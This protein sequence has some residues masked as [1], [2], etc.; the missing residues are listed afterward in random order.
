MTSTDHSPPPCGLSVASQDDTRCPRALHRTCWC[1]TP[2]LSHW[3]TWWRRCWPVV[4]WD[5]RCASD[6]TMHTLSTLAGKQSGGRKSQRTGLLR[7]REG[8][9]LR[10]PLS[11]RLGQSRRTLHKCINPSYE[12]HS[13]LSRTRQYVTHEGLRQRIFWG[14]LLCPPMVAAPTRQS[15]SSVPYQ[16]RACQAQA[17]DGS[18]RRLRH[19]VREKTR[20][21]VAKTPEFTTAS[22]STRNSN[23]VPRSQPP[24]THRPSKI[25]KI[26]QNQSLSDQSA[27][28][29]G[30]QVPQQPL[31]HSKTQTQNG[32]FGGNF[33]T[34]THGS[35][36]AA[37]D[38]VK[39]GHSSRWVITRSYRKGVFFFQILYSSTTARR[40]RPCSALARPINAI[41]RH[42]FFRKRLIC[43]KSARQR[44]EM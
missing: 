15:G 7:R 17:S 14:R 40:S 39:L 41:L 4:V 26:L 42:T 38:T 30:V 21:I 23:T 27:G 31:R 3:A 25:P 13:I 19:C 44:R 33:P 43:A 34:R 11:R 20:C 2:T 29:A 22:A 37:K 32:K 16:A 5:V 10:L 18:D 28:L 9:A 6:N 8:C 1:Q 24:I 36:S 35:L 12:K